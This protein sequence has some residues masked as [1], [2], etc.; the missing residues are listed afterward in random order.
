LLRIV[1]HTACSPQF[2]AREI[3]AFLR[4]IGN[5]I[6]ASAQAP[7]AKFYSIAKAAAHDSARVIALGA[8][9]ILIKSNLVF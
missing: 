9:F 5:S 6:A 4:K 2:G 7:K 1:R 8:Q 3:R